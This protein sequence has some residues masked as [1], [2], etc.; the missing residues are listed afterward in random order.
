MPN[1]GSR[2]I[3][4]DERG[5][6]LERCNAAGQWELQY[7]LPFEHPFM[8]EELRDT[9]NLNAGYQELLRVYDMGP[10]P[11]ETF[12]V[13]EDELVE[14]DTTGMT[15]KPEVISEAVIV[16]IAK[17]NGQYPALTLALEDL[18]W[19]PM[20]ACYFFARGGKYYTIGID[21]T[22]TSL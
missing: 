6:I 8:A 14:N 21:G 2:R 15:A 16:T 9:L 18:R 7:M 11:F 19:D 17:F 13:I 1:E 4:R 20:G 12:P 10:P 5:A 22:L 3:K